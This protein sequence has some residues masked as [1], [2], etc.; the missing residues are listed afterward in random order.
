MRYYIF[1]AALLV[2]LT[3]TAPNHAETGNAV[4]HCISINNDTERL[5]C[6][7]RLFRPHKDVKTPEAVKTEKEP[8]K[9]PVRSA[10]SAVTPDHSSRDQIRENNFGKV[11]HEDATDSIESILAG[12][13]KGWGRNSVF[14]LENGQTWRAVSSNARTKKLPKAL[15]KPK[16]TISRGAFGSYN[17]KIEGVRGKLKVRRVD[18]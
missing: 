15:I 13:F 17:L 12:N 11:I 9:A 2:C 8:A 3:S 18:D 16:V 1:I 6:Y 14:V 4:N 7:D 10:S 5:L